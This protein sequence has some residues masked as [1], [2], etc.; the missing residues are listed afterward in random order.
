MFP[1]MTSNKPL[2]TALAV[3][4]QKPDHR[5][6][7]VDGEFYATLPLELTA[8]QDLYVGAPFGEEEAEALLLAA[9]LVPA[10]EKAYQYLAYGDLSRNRLYE[11]LTRFGIEPQVAD[12]ACDKME[13][14]GFIDDDRLANRLAARYAQSKLWGPRRILT[15]MIQKGIPAPLAQE[16]TEALETD[17]EES[18]LAHLAGKY[19]NRNLSDPKEV[20]KVIQGL[21]RL[22]F[23]YETIRNGLHHAAEDFDD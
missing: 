5:D 8:Q 22:G 20:Q 15:E 16:A 1:P 2:I 12:A 18:V 7:F 4:P 21:L 17:F 14:Q 23:D 19:R 13:E 3:N 10:K 6:L 11:K 9:Q